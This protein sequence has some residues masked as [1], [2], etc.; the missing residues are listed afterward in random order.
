M[1]RWKT[2]ATKL[3]AAVILAVL[4]ANC[5][6]G[7]GAGG[8]FGSAENLAFEGWESYRVADL[9]TAEDLFISALNIDPTFSEAYNGLA[10][11]K[12]KQAG[13]EKDSERRTRLL[14][15]ALENYQRAVQAD[16]TNS[17]AWAGLAGL[18]LARSNWAEAA[19]SA[20]KTLE[21]NPR[22][23]SSHDNIDWRDIRLL[24]AQALFHQGEF[25]SENPNDPQAAV[26][27]LEYVAR[28]FRQEYIDD[29]LTEAD[30]IRKI[31]EL[32]GL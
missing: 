16:P 21:S 23:F 30:I 31:E 17:D 3:S 1:I 27:Q 10:W 11:L 7:T 29:E 8:T 20:L 5:G 26:N 18:E 9:E 24:W 14:D 6:G 22:Y 28:G 19:N 12:F 2:R 32:Q 4:A 25:F 15:A 13:L